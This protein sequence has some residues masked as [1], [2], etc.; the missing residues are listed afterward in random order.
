MTPRDASPEG[1]RPEIAVIGSGPGRTPIDFKATVAAL[2][3]AI[4]GERCPET[5]PGEIGADHPVAGFILEA[6]ARMPGHL[7]MPLTSLTVAFALWALPFTGRTF[8][9]LPS[10]TRR[11]QIRAWRESRL[12]VRRDLI[13]FYE[14]LAIFGWYA[15]I[16]AQ[17]HRHDAT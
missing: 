6:H 16:Y 1:L 14:T 12:G 17:D 13:K 9:R 4:I 7:R 3:D 15:E 11:R 10:D 8:H 2:A 5:Y